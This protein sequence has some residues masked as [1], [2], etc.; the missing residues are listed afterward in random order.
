MGKLQEHDNRHSFHLNGL[1]FAASRASK[2]EIKPASD[3]FNEIG[4]GSAMAQTKSSSAQEWRD[5]WPL[6]LAATLGI[7][8]GAIPTVTLGLFME[9]LQAEFGW[10]RTTISLGMTVFALL[11]LPLTPL[12]GAL[13]DKLGAR[14]I[15]IPGLI[16]CGLIFAA[17]STM[18][19]AVWVW[20]AMWVI[21]S[22]GSVLIRT[23][24][25]NPPVSSAFVQNRGMAI[26]ILL[27]GISLAA[28]CTP[29]LTHSLIQNVGWRGAYIGLGI[30]WAG[31]ALLL[32]VPFFRD[33][34]VRNKSASNPNSAQPTR[35]IPGGLTGK[36]AMRNI[37]ILRVAAAG[38]VATTLTAAYSVHM[39][40]IYVSLGVER[41]A[42]A[43]I[44]LIVGV[45]AVISKIVVG[46]IAD[47]VNSSFLPFS[48][49]ALPAV[50]YGI[51]LGAQ[52]STGWAITGAVVVGLGTGSVVHIIMYL[53]TQ[54]GG[55]RNFGKI[56][57]SVSALFGLASGIGPL[58]AGRIFDITGNYELFLMIG[59]P[60]FVLSGLLV[61][62]LGAF[63]EFTPT[64][65]ADEPAGASSPTTH[66]TPA[67]AQ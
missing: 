58:V 13:V 33:T 38:L 45:A 53:T 16:L 4:T 34:P 42:A 59:I 2:K 65:I 35:T 27:C 18:N 25:W 52:G 39:V 57:G 11:V 7:S 41:G 10:S 30:G 50:G 63:P 43:G 64:E 28:A 14:R 62:G 26:A 54:Y 20:I 49:F 5:H 9:P 44:A 47:R 60:M 37:A 46:L 15:A 61:F 67:A 23:M 40:P 12:A 3:R 48:V 17:F 8:F 24:V 66:A 21:Y 32:V 51:L 36:E 56:Y 1:R 55:L 6:L 29:L 22:T 31:L 19:G